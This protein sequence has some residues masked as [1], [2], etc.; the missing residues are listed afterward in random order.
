VLVLDSGVQDNHPDLNIVPGSGRDFVPDIPLDGGVPFT[1]L[2]NHG[3]AVAGVIAARINGVGTV[4]VAP[5]AF[6]VSAKVYDE[7]S[8]G[9]FLATDAN[10][11]AAIRY[12][13]V[14]GARVT[15]SSFVLGSGSHLLITNAYRDTRD[16]GVFHV[17]AAGNDSIAF[18]RYPA[19]LS[20]VFSAGSLK[21][22]GLISSFSNH[23]F[24]LDVVAPGQDIY[25]TDR[26][27]LDGYN[28]CNGDN[29]YTIDADLNGGD[30][31]SY[32]SPHV[33]G[34]A[35][36]MLSKNPTLTPIEVRNI[37][38]STAVDITPGVY[39]FGFDEFTGHGLV[40]AAAAVGGVPPRA[41]I[42]HDGVVNASDLAMV[43]AS[44]GP[45]PAPPE[46]CGADL[47]DD[48][49]VNL[50]DLSMVLGAWM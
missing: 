31:T 50:Q 20:A 3:T 28:C 45:C 22:D 39:G 41:D 18:L 9:L 36:L 27:G 4:G 30:G 8:G 29:N 7:T 26:T 37:L 24:D 14:V 21:R 16:A 23:D 32:A 19:S 35:A 5:G 1:S 12:S 11:A 48:G 38:R 2:D 6:I 47:N 43:L 25:T 44:W 46:I 13:L 49:M 40:N 10:F 15:N 34:I 33:A 42:N 17:A